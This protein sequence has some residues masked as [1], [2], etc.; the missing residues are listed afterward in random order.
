MLWMRILLLL[1]PRFLNAFLLWLDGMQSTLMDDLWEVV[2][3]GQ[4][5]VGHD[6]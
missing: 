3:Q 5:V 2:L 4:S 1:T 6:E